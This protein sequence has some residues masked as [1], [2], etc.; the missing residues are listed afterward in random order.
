[1]TGLDVTAHDIL[2]LILDAGPWL[3]I[4]ARTGAFHF[5]ILRGSV[6]MLATGSPVLLALALLLIRFAVMAAALGVI[7]RHSGAVALLVAA[8]GVLA[9]RTAAVRIGARL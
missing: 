5:L 3:A 1:M 4:G 8:I 2:E 9:S 7:I 6:Q